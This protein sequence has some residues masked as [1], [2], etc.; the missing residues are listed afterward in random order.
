MIYAKAPIFGI[1]MLALAGC[2]EGI[3]TYEA[4][5]VSVGQARC[6]EQAPRPLQGKR[7]SGSAN[8]DAEG[9][10]QAVS[11]A[12]SNLGGQTVEGPRRRCQPLMQEAVRLAKAEAALKS[13][14]AAEAAQEARLARLRADQ[15][16]R[17]MKGETAG[18]EDKAW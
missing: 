10:I 5:N 17:L 12:V 14:E 16:E 9:A 1:G 7:M 13:A 4:V 15:E 11:A 18:L 2:A 6:S 8:L 3:E